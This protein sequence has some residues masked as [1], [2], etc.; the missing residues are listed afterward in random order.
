MNIWMNGEE[1]AFPRIGI[2]DKG[3]RRNDENK[4]ND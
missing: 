3:C 4:I 2:L 1:T